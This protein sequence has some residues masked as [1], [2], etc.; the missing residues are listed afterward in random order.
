M[1]NLL[2]SKKAGS[3]L[4]IVMFFVVITS[5]MG[6]AVLAIGMQ[7]RLFSIRTAA[8]IA[9]RCAA[10][11]GLTKAVYQM[12]QK[13]FSDKATLG[14]WNTDPAVLPS[15]TNAALSACDAVYSYTITKSG[16]DYVVTS[17]GTCGQA[18]KQITCTI[19]IQGPFDYALLVDQWVWLYS[20]ST[21][22]QYNTDA[23]TPPLRVGTNSTKWAYL[24]LFNDAKI[25]GDAVVGV[26]G[27][28]GYVV[29]NKGTITGSQ[30]SMTE[31]QTL[32]SVTVP[33]SLAALPSEETMKTDTTLTTSAKYKKID[34][35]NSEILTIDGDVSLYVT[36]DILLGNSA[37]IIV[38]PNAS[39]KI[40]VGGKVLCGNKTNINNLTKDPHKTLI[41]G[42]DT[43]TDIGINSDELYGAIY[44]PKATVTYYNSADLYGSIVAKNFETKMSTRIHYDAL[45][46]KVAINDDAV[47]FVI[48]RWS[49]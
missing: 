34:L 47:R 14:A 32:P 18:Q 4:A 40:Y 20:S 29:D 43:C 49:E 44:A 35:G 38:N 30:Y 36:G 31:T 12:N 16:S 17:T 3:I 37:E 1:R 24:C 10:D 8:E 5:I 39:L 27:D 19:A 33:A 2:Q 15:A 46:R 45:L 11:A 23:S 41:Y 26:N 28:P 21:V 9:A 13:L 6:V 7:K 42:L 22:D 48:N 25:D